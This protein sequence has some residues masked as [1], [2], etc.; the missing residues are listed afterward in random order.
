MV[1]GL[2]TIKNLDFDTMEDY[3]N[4]IVDS[5]INGNTKQ[6]KELFNKLSNEQKKNFFMWIEINEIKN[7]S[8]IDFI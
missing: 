8:I 1:V 3:F 2:K 7:I 6:M 5:E 4:Y